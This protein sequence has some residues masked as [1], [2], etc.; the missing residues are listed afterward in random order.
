[1]CDLGF[2]ACE[3]YTGL[4]AREFSQPVPTAMTKHR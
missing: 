4:T 1:M 2:A 3:E